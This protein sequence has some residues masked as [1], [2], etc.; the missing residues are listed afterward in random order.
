VLNS[1]QPGYHHPAKF[2]GGARNAGDIA[3]GIKLISVN[4]MVHQK[5]TR[6]S[7]PQKHLQWSSRP[8]K[9]LGIPIR[10]EKK[11]FKMIEPTTRKG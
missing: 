9:N 7:M 2:F 4:S 8:R 5:R 6:K 11:E 10:W 3:S 1:N